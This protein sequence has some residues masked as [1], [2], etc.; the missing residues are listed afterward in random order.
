MSARQ[1]AELDIQEELSR[2]GKCFIAF[3][4]EL[5]PVMDELVSNQI[6]SQELCNS[7]KVM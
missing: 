6:K 2:L 7:R 5:N 4:T 3:R 1:C